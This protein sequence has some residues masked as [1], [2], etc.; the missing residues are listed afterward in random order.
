M[1]NYQIDHIININ[2]FLRIFENFGGNLNF[3]SDGF[4]T[5]PLHKLSW[6]FLI[7]NLIVLQNL[8]TITYAH[9]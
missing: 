1:T 7:L 3:C 9:V 8:P 5:Q 6:H 4:L 2:L